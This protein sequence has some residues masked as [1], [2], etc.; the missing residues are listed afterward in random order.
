MTACKG[1]PVLET[2]CSN[3]SA[4]RSGA[5]RSSRPTGG[6]DS[7]R[8][9]AII[10]SSPKSSSGCSAVSFGRTGTSTC[11]GST[12]AAG[13]PPRVSP[14]TRSCNGS[15]SESRSLSGEAPI[16]HRRRSRR[17]RMPTASGLRWAQ[18][19]FRHPRGRDGGDRQRAE[20]PLL[21]RL[22]IDVPGLQRLHAWSRAPRGADAACHRSSSTPTTRSG[23]ARTVPPTSRSS[24]SP[25]CARS[26]VCQ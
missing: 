19:A 6:G 25:A 16:S 9:V 21:P 1:S 22:R 2:R 8:T 4:A 11:L 23:L 20:R 3:A 7:G 18:P 24:S 17:S 13:S 10:L 14:R 12:S 26:Q 5:A 15:Q